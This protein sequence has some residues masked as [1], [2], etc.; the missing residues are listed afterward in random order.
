[1][2]FVFLFIFLNVY[3]VLLISLRFVNINFFIYICSKMFSIRFCHLYYFFNISKWFL[4]CIRF[5]IF[6]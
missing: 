2:Y 3:I 6:E 4:I 1:M 5:F